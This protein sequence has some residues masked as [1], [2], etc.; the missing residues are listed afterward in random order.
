M[1]QP[2]KLLLAISVFSFFAAAACAQRDSL[3]SPPWVSDK[4]YWTLESNVH[5]PKN[6]IIRFYNY[7]N[8]LVYTEHLQGVILNLN[9]RKTK[10]KLKNALEATM[11]RLANLKQPEADKDYVVAILK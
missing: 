8:K 7:D 5:T 10:M 9:K 2:F 1:K 4:G 3:S 6:H 11:L